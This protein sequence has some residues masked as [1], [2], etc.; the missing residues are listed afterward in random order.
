MIP[1]SQSNRFEAINTISGWVEYFERNRARLLTIPWKN[2]GSLTP[3]ELQ[4]I[5]DSIRIFQLGESSEG[6][7]LIR[8]AELYAIRS[9]E[10]ALVLAIK[11]FIAEEQRHAADLARF[12]SDQ[13]IA[14]AR[15]QWTDTVF[16]TLRRFWNLEVSVSVLLTAE[17]V[18]KVYYKALQNAT[19]SPVLIQI[20]RQLLRDEAAHV[21]FH[22]K[23]LGLTRVNRASWMIRCQNLFY[24]LFHIC[25]LLVVWREHQNV[26]KAGNY[27]F[28]LYWKCS[29]LHFCQAMKWIEQVRQDNLLPFLAVPCGKKNDYKLRPNLGL[30]R[31]PVILIGRTAP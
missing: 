16:R 6:R 19:A 5:S 27:P 14:L 10:Q 17:L 25:T 22:T 20:C 31:V 24:K 4:T 12:M 18:A 1:I 26:F 23:I 7:H 2:K 30:L 28:N 15:K 13:G 11:L 8:V 3:Q 21:R 29:Q 9:R